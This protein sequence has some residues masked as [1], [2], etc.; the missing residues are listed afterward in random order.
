MPELRVHRSPWGDFPDVIVQTNM[1]KLQG[2]PAYRAA[3]E[4]D[5]VAAFQ[6]VESVRKRSKVRWEV[7]EIVAVAQFDRDKKNALPIAYAILLGREMGIPVNSTVVQE[8][9]VSHTGADAPTRVLGQPIFDGVIGEGKRILI[10]DDVVTF[11]A[12]LA[13]LRGFIQSCGG[14]VVGASTLSASYGGT[15]LA[16]PDHVKQSLFERFPSVAELA[17]GLGF[18]PDCFTNREAR[19]LAA[20]KEHEKSVLLAT[21][22]ALQQARAQGIHL[23]RNLS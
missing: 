20:L 2:H 3:K 17:Q 5:M 1:T 9:I 23:D 14:A 10:V 21:V 19:F 7:D 16:L 4:G 11:G 12:T 15:K 6:V 18:E 13:N 8:N 22:K